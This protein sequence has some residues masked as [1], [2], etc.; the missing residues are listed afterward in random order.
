MN[1]EY[2]TDVGPQLSPECL[3]YSTILGPPLQ[4]RETL[5]CNFV[6]QQS[7][8]NNCQFSIG[9]QSPNMVSSDTDDDV[10]ISSGLLIASKLYRRR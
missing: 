6:V 8:L 3:I 5:S 9:K 10:I 2:S 1:E 4:G 7:W